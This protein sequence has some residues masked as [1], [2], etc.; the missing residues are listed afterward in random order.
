MDGL[1]HP[2]GN[3]EKALFSIDAL[4]PN[5]G[6]HLVRALTEAN[7]SFVKGKRKRGRKVKRA[8]WKLP[9]GGG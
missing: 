8:K 6:N 5:E 2:V 7:S 4:G 1:V 3:I 9:R